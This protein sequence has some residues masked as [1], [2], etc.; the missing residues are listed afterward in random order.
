[1]FLSVY[2]HGFF[3]GLKVRLVAD[4]KTLAESDLKTSCIGAENILIGLLT[5]SPASYD[6]LTG[7]KPLTGT[8][9]VAQIGLGD[10]PD[11]VTGWAGLDALVISGVDTSGLSA[12]PWNCGSRMAAGCSSLVAQNG[13]A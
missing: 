13:K 7:V 9:K 5:D 1:L 11:Q 12:R 10:L 8:V 6:A 4:G 2:P 3:S